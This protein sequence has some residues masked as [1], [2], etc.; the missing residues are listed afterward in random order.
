MAFFTAAFC[1]IR[2]FIHMGNIAD[3]LTCQYMIYEHDMQFNISAF[4]LIYI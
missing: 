3:K 1:R 4:T 2:S